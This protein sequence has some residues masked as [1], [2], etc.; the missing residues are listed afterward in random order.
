MKFL[1][2]DNVVCLSPHPDDTE[3]SM[4][5]T[6]LK[7]YDTKFYIFIMS[8]GGAPGFDPS[9]EEFDRRE[10]VNNFWRDIGAQNVNVIYSNRDYLENRSEPGW[11]NH[12]ENLFFTE[13]GNN[14]I[15]FMGEPARCL[16]IPPREDSQ[17]EHQFVNKLGYGLIRCLPITLIEYQT[18]STLNAWNSNLNINI[19]NE[20]SRKI[21]AMK[22]FISQINKSIFTDTTLQSFHYDYK[23]NRR[24]IKYSEKFKILEY[25]E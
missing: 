18:V 22:M 17:F 23:L 10:E 1:G 4:G 11:I 2:L 16:M 7:H 14:Q 13:H 12:I 24:G 19:T 9:N 21:D 15:D 25:F 5:G 3:Y 20:Y 8:K 6:I